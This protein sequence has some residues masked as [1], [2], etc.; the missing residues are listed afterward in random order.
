M[1]E[2]KFPFV[3][4]GEHGEVCVRY[5][6]NGDPARWGF[7]LLGLEGEGSRA[8]AFPAMEARVS[9]AREGYAAL[10]G[11]VQIVR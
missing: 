8:A 6:K 2:L 4:R 11:W 10:F 5:V 1:V 3:A 7:D 9:Y